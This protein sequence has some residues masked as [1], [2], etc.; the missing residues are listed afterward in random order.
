[1]LPLV[2]INIKLFKLLL[3]IY[4]LTYAQQTTL[5]SKLS[6]EESN[7]ID[8][9]FKNNY[10]TSIRPNQTVNGKFII[11][12][13]QLIGVDSKSKS[14]QSNFDLLVAW[15]DPRLSWNPKNHSELTRVLIEPK[16]IWLPDFC[17]VNSEESDFFLKYTDKKYALIENDG[18]ISISFKLRGIKTKCETNIYKFPFDKHRCP[19]IVS[20]MAMSDEKFNFVLDD[21]NSLTQ[22]HLSENPDWKL[23]SLDVE[24]RKSVS[25]RYATLLSNYKM[26]DAILYIN[27][28]RKAMTFMF[29]GI[30]PCL[31]L[32]IMT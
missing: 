6:T 27:L 30:Y 23:N 10:S 20:S 8:E 1:M 31:F 29:Y 32:N 26:S 11:H 2:Q 24:N 28:E 3:I 5:Q 25:D 22:E 19:I 21:E 4:G 13:R 15:L 17:I 18:K 16:R 14:M 12:F 9:L 7:L